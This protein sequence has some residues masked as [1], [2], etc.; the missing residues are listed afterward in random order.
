MAV[1]KEGSQSLDHDEENEKLIA[2]LMQ[3]DADRYAAQ[4]LQGSQPHE[5]SQPME[6]DDL[7]VRA[8]D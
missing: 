3:E 1:S 2:Q 8:P 6:D 5:R 4:E 7:G